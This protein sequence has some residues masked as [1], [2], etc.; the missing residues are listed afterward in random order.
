MSKHKEIHKRKW[1]SPTDSSSL[2]YVSYTMY[3]YGDESMSLCIADCNRN[4][5]LHIMNKKDRRKIQTLIDFLN[6]A[7]SV[8][9]GEQ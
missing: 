1:L 6:Q 2:S 3:E 5:N 7:M 4:I 9:D 8:Y